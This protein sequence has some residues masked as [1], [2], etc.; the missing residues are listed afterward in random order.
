[1]LGK[2]S[3]LSYAPSYVLLVIALIC[4]DTREVSTF[5]YWALRVSR[6]PS[7]IFIVSHASAGPN[8]LPPGSHLHPLSHSVHFQS[9]FWGL[10]N[11]AFP[12]R[13][14]H[15]KKILL[16]ISQSACHILVSLPPP[17]LSSSPPISHSLPLEQMTHHVTPL[18]QVLQQSHFTQRSHQ[19]PYKIHRTLWVVSLSS[20]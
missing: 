1:M 7:H 11:P 6:F 4:Q 19:S 2:H 8:S 12:H 13:L 10:F 17:L 9:S 15:R 16:E 5:H 3:T 14:P 20:H 18:A